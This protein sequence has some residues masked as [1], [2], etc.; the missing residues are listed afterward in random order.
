M[1]KKQTYVEIGTIL[2]NRTK[3]GMIEFNLNGEKTQWDV[4]KAKEICQML[5]GAIEAAIS[6]TIIYKFMTEKVGLSEE[7]AVMTLVDFREM[8][9]GSKGTVYPF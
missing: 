9:Q 2:S 6:D 5:H 7:K 4:A 3:E 8:R 1:S